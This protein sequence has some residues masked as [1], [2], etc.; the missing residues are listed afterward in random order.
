[1]A[2]TR[3]CQS[4]QF[5]MNNSAVRARCWRLTQFTAVWLFLLPVEAAYAAQSNAPPVSASTEQSTTEKLAELQRDVAQLKSEL[6]LRQEIARLKQEIE[7]GSSSKPTWVLVAPWAALGVVGLAFAVAWV[8][9][10]WRERVGRWHKEPDAATLD[11]LGERLATLESRVSELNTGISEMSKSVTT[12]N[13]NLNELWKSLAMSRT[14]SG[15]PHP[16]R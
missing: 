11:K 15:A 8:L 1:M 12:V 16:E 4:L 3:S 10:N 5:G 9:L 13:G 6:G 14:T 7:E 2:L